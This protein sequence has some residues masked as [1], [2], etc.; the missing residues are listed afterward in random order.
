MML[1]NRLI[2]GLLLQI[3]G[4]A[5]INLDNDDVQYGVPEVCQSKYSKNNDTQKPYVFSAG[6]TVAVQ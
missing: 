5:P 6:S 4:R 2:Q 3:S 1:F